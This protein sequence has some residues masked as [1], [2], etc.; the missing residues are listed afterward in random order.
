MDYFGKLL[1]A[2]NNFN[3]KIEI[4]VNIIME[5]H[6]TTKLLIYD[7]NLHVFRHACFAY[8]TSWLSE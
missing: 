6:Y 8:S 2:E 1:N 4:V 3:K 5:T 7:I